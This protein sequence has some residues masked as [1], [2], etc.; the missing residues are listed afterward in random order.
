VTAAQTH[1]RHAQFRLDFIEAENSMGFHAAQE[2]ARILG[3]SIDDSRQG[4]VALRSLRRAAP[5]AAKPD[6]AK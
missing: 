1:Q 2:A 6:Y 3:M 4:Q 5:A